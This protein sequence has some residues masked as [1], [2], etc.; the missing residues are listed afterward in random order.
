MRC[1]YDAVLWQDG[2]SLVLVVISCGQRA[3]PEC[4]WTVGMGWELRGEN[5]K[6]VTEETN[7]AVT[8]GS[9]VSTLGTVSPDQLERAFSSSPRSLQ[10]WEALCAHAWFRLQALSQKFALQ[11]VRCSLETNSTATEKPTLEK[12]TV[13]NLSGSA[14]AQLP[15]SPSLFMYSI[16]FALFTYWRI[17][18]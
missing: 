15:L 14:S 17:C 16:F 8:V 6:R 7:A 3:L 10:Q 11:L 2:A 9:P 13:Y 18:T 4:I 1:L 5:V 12:D